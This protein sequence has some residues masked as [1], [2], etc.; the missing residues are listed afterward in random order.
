[1]ASEYLSALKYLR[2]ASPHWRPE[3]RLCSA[4]EGDEVWGKVST[5]I[6][7]QPNLPTIW[8]IYLYFWFE[9]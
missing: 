3:V 5:G 2:P 4:L 9:I 1:M 6:Y 8:K 7:R